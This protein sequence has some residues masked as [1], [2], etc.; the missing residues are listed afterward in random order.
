MLKY[1]VLRSLFQVYFL[2]FLLKGV[3]MDVVDTDTDDHYRAWANPL[4]LCSGVKVPLSSL[5]L[6]VNSEEDFV[7]VVPSTTPMPCFLTGLFARLVVVNRLLSGEGAEEEPNPALTGPRH[8]CTE[9]CMASALPAALSPPAPPVSG[10]C[11]DGQHR[12]AHPGLAWP[13]PAWSGAAEGMGWAGTGRSPRAQLG[14]PALLP[15]SRFQGA[16]HWPSPEVSQWDS[17]LL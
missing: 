15:S 8:S 10:L 1:G 11:R 12:A 5:W 7:D 2:M 3:N 16:H 17:A 4:S 6:P 9:L 14:L 13:G